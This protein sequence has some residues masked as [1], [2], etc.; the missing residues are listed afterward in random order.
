MSKGFNPAQLK[1]LDVEVSQEYQARNLAAL[2]LLD[3]WEN[4]TSGY[5]EENAEAI[6]RALSRTETE[7]FALREPSI[8]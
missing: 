5:E 8:K 7:P 1:A 2:A 3:T 6:D 4:D